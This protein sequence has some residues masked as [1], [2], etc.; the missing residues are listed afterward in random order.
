MHGQHGLSAAMPAVRRIGAAPARLQRGVGLIEV[1]IAV[2]VLAVG[3]LGLAALQSM[4]LKNVGS[5]AER[6]Q[7]AIQIYA[8]ADML[9]ADRANNS[10]YNTGG[11]VGAADNA[12]GLVADWLET[13]EAE[14]SPTAKGRVNCAGTA[15]CTIGVQWLDDRATGGTAGEEYRIELVTL[16]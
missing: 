6:T 5:S 2:V 13:L 16:L 3:L 14:V 12:N 9:R 4:T 8:M 1:L 7:A 10:S 15:T 11:Y